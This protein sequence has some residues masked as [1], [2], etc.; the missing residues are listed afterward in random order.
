MAESGDQQ[1]LAVVREGHDFH[2]G[3]EIRLFPN[4]HEVHL[5]NSEDGERI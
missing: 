2:P 5:F 3:D 4:E 1:I